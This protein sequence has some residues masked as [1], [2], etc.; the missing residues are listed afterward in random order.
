MRQ[1]LDTVLGWVGYGLGYAEVD[2]TSHVSVA[3]GADA[4]SRR[5]PT[6]TAGQ[7][8]GA[9][10]AK[11]PSPPSGQGRTWDR[12]SLNESTSGQHEGRVLK[13]RVLDRLGEIG[14]GLESASAWLAKA[15]GATQ[16]VQRVRDGFR[17]RVESSVGHVSDRA[18][19]VT[20]A[21]EQ[22]ATNW[23]ESSVRDLRIGRIWWPDSASRD[24]GPD[25]QAEA[26]RWTQDDTLSIPTAPKSATA[27][28]R[29]ESISTAPSGVS[30]VDQPV[31]EDRSVKVV[32]QVPDT[33]P[34]A[35]EKPLRYIKIELPEP[36]ITAS[37]LGRFEPEARVSKGV[38]TPSVRNEVASAESLNPSQ[39]LEPSAVAA[40]SN[41]S[42][43]D[44]LEVSEG[45]RTGV[46][47]DLRRSFSLRSLLPSF[48]RRREPQATT[49]FGSRP[50]G[51]LSPDELSDPH[52]ESSTV[53]RPA[54]ER[55]N[56]LLQADK[57]RE[58]EDV[59]D[60]PPE[61]RSDTH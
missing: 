10:M 60:P 59:T 13:D 27:P 51:A 31:K 28:A 15:M 1:H 6:P 44:S 61:D 8:D 17:A 54:L 29:A 46:G 18:T 49:L 9:P 36:S 4:R 35:I 52:A 55:L 24:S 57:E 37:E 30:A 39:D 25:V 3:D 38:E 48:L 40:S 11:A 41:D 26:E 14:T 12:N 56:R 42:R 47:Q 20:R 23:R 7:V 33:D 53:E 21:V 2:G 22:R 16:V 50:A 58:G 34:A 32:E 5:V 45:S 43:D 19:A